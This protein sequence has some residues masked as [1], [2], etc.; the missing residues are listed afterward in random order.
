M[1]ALVALGS[2]LGDR[3]AHLRS[4]LEGLARHGSVQPSPQVLETPDETGRGPDFLNTVARLDTPLVDVRDLLEA[5]LRLELDAGRDRSL[6]P[7]APRTL[8]LD[9][10]AVLGVRGTF[11]WTAPDDLT[12]LGATLSLVLP[13]P[14]ALRRPFVVEPWKALDPW[15]PPGLR[16]FDIAE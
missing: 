3:S 8:D 4:G 12:S 10:V 15:L 14:R 16:S 6:G 9:L 7:G 2:N 5:L 13:H 1:I 11:R